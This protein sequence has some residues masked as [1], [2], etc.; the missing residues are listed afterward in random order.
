MSKQL[1]LSRHVWRQV[2]PH[3][4]PS[5]GVDCDTKCSIICPSTFRTLQ[6]RGDKMIDGWSVCSY[7]RLGRVTWIHS[8][9]VTVDW[10]TPCPHT[11]DAINAN[12]GKGLS[13]KSFYKYIA[14]HGRECSMVIT[15]LCKMGARPREGNCWKIFRF[16]A[17]F[18]S[19]VVQ[20][21]RECQQL[22]CRVSIAI[23]TPINFH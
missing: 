14:W 8:R 12:K 11:R 6:L 1:F 4:L 15:F 3:R 20:V 17:V 19:L 16:Y 18:P 9:G 22:L 23:C 7:W 13:S 10:H 21:I 2:T 5:S